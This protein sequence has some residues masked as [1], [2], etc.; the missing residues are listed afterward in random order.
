[1]HN[2]FKQKL[3]LIKDD[4]EKLVEFRKT[5]IDSGNNK[6]Y[7]SKII[8]EIELLL[9]EDEVEHPLNTANLFT[10]SNG[11][12][13][14]L[15]DMYKN[16]SLLLVCNGPSAKSF[17]YIDKPTNMM[18]MGM[19]NGHRGDFWVINDHPSAF[20]LDIF[21]N[22]NITK[23]IP[24][25]YKNEVTKEDVTLDKYPNIVFFNRSEQFDKGKWLYERAIN[26]GNSPKNGK[27]RSTL[28]SCLNL[29]YVLGFKKIYLVGC[30]FHMSKFNPYFFKKE[31]NNN[32]VLGNNRNY[33]HSV[34]IL[35]DIKECLEKVG[36][37]VYNTNF[38][39]KLKVFKYKELK[40]VIK[41]HLA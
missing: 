1:M 15:V 20:D 13:L 5:L 21:K 31:V 41:E 26:Y 33:E 4:N 38:N 28:F 29:A 24:N 14:E 9:G 37:Q 6:S 8:R 25:K 2:Y 19:N 12:S 36:V 7:V 27:V 32:H 18:T 16:S 39:S 30:D 17:S 10:R 11:S 23:F 35:E 40:S 34:T 22:P 3:E